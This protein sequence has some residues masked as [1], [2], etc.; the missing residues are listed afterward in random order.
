[1]TDQPMNEARAREI[2]A[3]E[4]LPTYK[5]AEARSYLAG[6]EAGRKDR[7]KWRAMVGRWEAQAA[8]LAEAMRGAANDLGAPSMDYAPSVAVSEHRKIRTSV[9][10]RLAEALAAYQRLVQDF[11]KMKGESRD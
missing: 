10:L 8:L 9:A 7:D 5:A 4:T 6:L 2:V 3:N 11:E 1:M